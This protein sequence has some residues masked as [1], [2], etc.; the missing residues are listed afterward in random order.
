MD[1]YLNLGLC[2]SDGYIAPDCDVLIP[3]ISVHFK[4]ASSGDHTN[5]SEMLEE[6]AGTVRRHMTTCTKDIYLESAT[7]VPFFYN[8]GS[9][10]TVV[11]RKSLCVAHH[12]NWNFED[13]FEF[14]GLDAELEMDP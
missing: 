1:Y 6:I 10:K 12:A 13:E 14:V 9:Y 8:T 7:S 4:L 3:K 2:T 5:P 11:K